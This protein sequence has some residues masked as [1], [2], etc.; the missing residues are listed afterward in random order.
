MRQFQGRKSG[1]EVRKSQALIRQ[2]STNHARPGRR[3]RRVRILRLI[4]KERP[5]LAPI[6]LSRRQTMRDDRKARRRIQGNPGPL[7]FY[8]LSMDLNNA[9][10]IESLTAGSVAGRPA[11]YQP[12]HPKA[13]NRG[14][15]L[16]ARHVMECH[17]GR[18][19][20]SW[21]E[22]H[23]KDENEKNDIISNLEVKT[24]SQHARDHML[25][26]LGERALD[27]ALVKKLYVQ[28]GSPK[29]IAKITGYKLKSVKSIL[30][31]KPKILLGCPQ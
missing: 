17:L 15:I 11:V 31:K 14:L 28:Y 27:W 21:E 10:E 2:P 9:L 19:L 6:E 24:T 12:G 26:R 1:S 7:S 30:Y 16:R 13:S 5:G 29:M 4:A 20:E 3:G 8:F 18:M 23:H 22:V 25:E